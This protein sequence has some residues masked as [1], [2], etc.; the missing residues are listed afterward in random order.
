MQLVVNN[1]PK[2]SIR[3][4]TDAGFKQLPNGRK[5]AVGSALISFKPGGSIEFR[6][7]LPS[8]KSSQEAELLIILE[9]LKRIYDHLAR[10]GQAHLIVDHD[11]TIFSDNSGCERF[12]TPGASIPEQYRE[13]Y[14]P[15]FRE[16][17][18]FKEYRVFCFSQS[19]YKKIKTCDSMCTNLIKKIEKESLR[20]AI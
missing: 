5:I 10:S 1:S 13:F 6:Q 9:G 4:Y 11:L 14:V 18:L 20:E 3:M 2:R 15:F 7:E 16:L 8:A 19:D 12:L 17:S